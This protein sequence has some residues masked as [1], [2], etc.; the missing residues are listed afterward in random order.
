[1]KIFKNNIFSTK[2]V[3]TSPNEFI[4][5]VSVNETHLSAQLLEVPLLG[6][7]TVLRLG[8]DAW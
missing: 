5:F 4:A 6:A 2:V 3:P 7:G 8:R 1:M